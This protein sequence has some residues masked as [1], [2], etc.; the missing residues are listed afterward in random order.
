[1]PSLQADTAVNGRN[2]G[3]LSLAFRRVANIGILN[4]EDE[5]NVE[6]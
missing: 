5:L 4:T 2:S 6:S 1:M 3:V